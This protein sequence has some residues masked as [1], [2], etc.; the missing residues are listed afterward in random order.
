MRCGGRSHDVVATILSTRGEMVEQ[1]VNA[2]V[3]VRLE[4]NVFAIGRRMRA[5]QHLEL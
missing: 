1:A 4:K 3:G 5:V 2:P